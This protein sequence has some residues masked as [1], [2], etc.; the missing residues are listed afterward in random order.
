[1]RDSAFERLF[2]CAAIAATIVASITVAA[3]GGGFQTGGGISGTSVVFGQIGGFGSI[4][5]NGIEFDTTNAV[6]TL[7]GDPATENDLR[8]GMV[9]SVRGI[10]DPGGLTGTAEIVA[11][12]DLLE[13]PVEGVNVGDGTFMAFSQLVIT[14][15][16]TVFDGTTLATLVAGEDVEVSG[17]YDADGSVRATRVER[18]LVGVEI[19][20]KGTVSSLDLVAETF[21]FG[22]L[23]ID[24]SGA[25][26]EGLPPGGIVDGLFVEVEAAAPA[27][28][29][30]LTAS[31]VE[32]LD[33][34]LMAD[35][36]DAAA[37]EGFITAIVSADEFVVNATQ[38]VIITPDT[39]FEGGDLG[40][41]VLNARVEVDGTIDQDGA[42]I[43]SEIEFLA[44]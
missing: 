15:A 11:M 40:D 31:G 28:A 1:M 4:I 22:L 26:L 27:A 16:E 34:I 38:Q 43:A 36:G 12:E 6:I 20:I 30:L 32:T 9:V 35:I 14:D 39:R 24:Y 7:E 8:L 2:G 19:E 10:V 18:K 41:V 29:D 13:G 21:R 44:P 3:C 17:F 25:L 37:V 5:V 23:T 33:Q 42:I